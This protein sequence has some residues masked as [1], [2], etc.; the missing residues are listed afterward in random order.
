MRLLGKKSLHSYHTFLLLIAVLHLSALF[1]HLSFTPRQPLV[2]EPLRLKVVRLEEIHRKQ[3]VQSQ[4]SSNREEK[5][6]AFLSDKTRSFERQTRARKIDTFK[7]ARRGGSPKSGDKRKGLELSQLGVN[8]KGVDPLAHAAKK[9]AEAKK[10][11]SH[12]GERQ[13]E[14]E[15]L[16]R[17]SSTNDH[18]EEIPLG[19]LTELNTVEYKYYGFYHRIRQRLEQFWGRSIQ[20]KAQEMI[21][22]GRQIAADEEHVTALQITLDAE[23]RVIG[24]SVMGSSGIRE[25]DEAAVES[26]NEA[27]PFPNPP[28]DLI[29]D[30][31]VV[32][33][34]GFVVKT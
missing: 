16:D 34:W 33:E 8:P 4:D 14:E 6:D 17:V 31:R 26:F 9:Y 28:K 20:D 10:G 21:Q 23:G 15:N 12:P 22:G 25:L 2:D 19:D 30:G 3:I 5:K 27:G 29:V 7:Q 18:I 32:L 13:A 24:I 1:K 11:K